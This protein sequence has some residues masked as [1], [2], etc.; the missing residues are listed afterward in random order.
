MKWF[1]VDFK[2]DPFGICIPAKSKEDVIRIVENPL[3]WKDG[4]S[5]II[6]S[7]KEEQ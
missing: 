6:D 4:K 2:N 7:I 1:S 3:N 5:R